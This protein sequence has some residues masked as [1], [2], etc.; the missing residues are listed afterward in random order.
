LGLYVPKKFFKLQ[1]WEERTPI[2]KEHQRHSYKNKKEKITQIKGVEKGEGMQTLV[3]V[4]CPALRASKR[5]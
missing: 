5:M 2:K 4:L 3:V 1:K